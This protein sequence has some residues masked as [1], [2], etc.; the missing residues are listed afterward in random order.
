MVTRPLMERTDARSGVLGPPLIPS[1]PSRTVH[2]LRS[3]IVVLRERS[4][5]TVR[6]PN[7]N[8]KVAT[9]RLNSPS[10]KLG[11]FGRDVGIAQAVFAVKRNWSYDDVPT[12]PNHC[13]SGFVCQIW[14]LRLK[15][16]ARNI[17]PVVAKHYP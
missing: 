5:R 15:F 14:L 17:L 11:Q 6:I 10:R 4:Q 7:T 8:W 2:P 16:D 12:G 1:D 9:W 3:D 13:W